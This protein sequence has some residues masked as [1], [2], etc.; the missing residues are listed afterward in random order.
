[1][2]R[3]SAGGE[4]GACGASGGGSSFRMA[5]MRLAW[6]LPPNGRVPV[7]IS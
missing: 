1:M 4:E 7:A 3:S 5:E 2:I 6:L